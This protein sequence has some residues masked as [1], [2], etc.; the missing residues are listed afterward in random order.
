MVS[1][2]CMTFVVH[3]ITLNHTNGTETVTQRHVT[4]I[5]ICSLVINI[6][7]ILRTLDKEGYN[8]TR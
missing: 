3:N 5:G 6:C 4:V 7:V 8:H 2:Y 1:T